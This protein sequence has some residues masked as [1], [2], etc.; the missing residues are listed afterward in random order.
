MHVN[1]ATVIAVAVVLNVLAIAIVGVRLWQR[2]K[3]DKAGKLLASVYFGSHLD[4]LFALIALVRYTP[5][6]GQE[7]ELTRY[8]AAS[9]H[10]NFCH[11]YLGRRR[12]LR[13]NAL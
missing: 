7:P 10:C 6:N 1:Q 3:S 11:H 5:V 12:R 13:G 9:C 8:I 4:D 2:S